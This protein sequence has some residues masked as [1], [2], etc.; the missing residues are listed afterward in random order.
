M[1]NRTF[2]KYIMDNYVVGRKKI[3]WMMVFLKN[4]IETEYGLDIFG[5]PDHSMIYISDDD[6]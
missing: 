4:R 3:S 5:W 6:N 1:K 2:I